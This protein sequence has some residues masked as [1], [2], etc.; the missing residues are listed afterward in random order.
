[1]TLYRVVVSGTAY[2]V[3]IGDPNARPVRA[4]VNGQ[5]VEVWVEEQ[6]VA[7]A[8]AAAGLEQ[9]QQPAVRPG[10]V[11]AHL[12]RSLSGIG[13]RILAPLP[14]SIISIA[15]APGDYV[16]AGQDVCVLEAMKMNNRI[17]ATRGG[18]IAEVHISVGDQVQH[19]DPLV[20]FV[21]DAA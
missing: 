2:Q 11:P 1:M 19:G 15:V 4:V 21:D 6:D 14:G 10:T 13:T 20:T 16:S 18:R 17:R 12:D 3:E 8:G 7:Q 5:V 9:A